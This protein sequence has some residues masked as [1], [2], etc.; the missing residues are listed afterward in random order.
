M[1]RA[2]SRP[3]ADRRSVA[4]GGSVAD[5]GSVA[6]WI[7]V[8]SLAAFLMAGLVVEGGQTLAARESAA[9]LAGQAAR[10]GANALAPQSLRNGLPGDVTFD[11]TLAVAAANA[12]L[13]A[14]HPTSRT[15]TVAADLK[16]V[17]VTVVISKPTVILA[18]IDISIVSGSAKETATTVFGGQDQLG[19]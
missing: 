7:A 5:C 14:A 9:G 12:V 4:D 1:T 10:A 19:G 3:T 6:L 8:T 15:V 11:P 18:A 13:D 17:T 2:S 16:S